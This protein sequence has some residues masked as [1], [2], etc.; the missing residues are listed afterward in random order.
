MNDNAGW[1]SI[2][3]GNLRLT[4]LASAE[5]PAFTDQFWP[6]CAMDRTID[7]ATT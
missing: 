4:S 7:P 5:Q 2:A 6:R 3:F 1:E